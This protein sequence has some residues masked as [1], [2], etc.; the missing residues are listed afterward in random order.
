MLFEIVYKNGGMPTISLHNYC[1]HCAPQFPSGL[2]L[3][4][5]VL[6]CETVSQLNGKFCSHLE[7]TLS[8][9][10]YR[11]MANVIWPDQ[12]KHWISS[13]E[14]DKATKRSLERELQQK[15][16]SAVKN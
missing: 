12:F 8:V 4:A 6:L 3:L 15:C 5:G 9:N 14:V 1:F 13:T 16:L 11:G 10:L 7:C 2:L